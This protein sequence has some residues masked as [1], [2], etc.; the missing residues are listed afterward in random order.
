MHNDDWVSATRESEEIL[1]AEQAMGKALRRL[2]RNL[3]DKPSGVAAQWTETVN[4]TCFISQ[5][6]L[7]SHLF[8]LSPE[9]C[10]SGYMWT[11]LDSQI[12]AGT[13]LIPLGQTDGQNLLFRLGKDINHYVEKGM[14]MPLTDVGLSMPSMAM[15]SAWHEQQYSRLFR[16]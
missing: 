5:F 3:T 2:L 7:A 9:L 1:L 10:L 11:I 4:S 8:G 14:N 12:A 6:A 13:K 15:A 16:S